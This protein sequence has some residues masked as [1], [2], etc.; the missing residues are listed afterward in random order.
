MYDSIDRGGH[1][2]SLM[3]IWAVG[4]GLITVCPVGPVG[5]VGSGYDIHK[6]SSALNLEN[7]TCSIQ[8][9]L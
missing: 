1:A 4:R 6:Q 3:I 7:P 8:H 2:Y 5:P 9:D